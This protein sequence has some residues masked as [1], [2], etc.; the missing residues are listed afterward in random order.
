MHFVLPWISLPFGSAHLE[1]RRLHSD[2]DRGSLARKF[3]VEK[4]LSV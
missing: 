4:K 3:L 2:R 1:L